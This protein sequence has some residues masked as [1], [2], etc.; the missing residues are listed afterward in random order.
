MKNTRIVFFGTTTFACGILQTLIDEKYNVVAVVS[1]PDKPVGRK[2]VIQPT[3][4]HTLASQYQIPVVQPDVLRNHIEDVLQYEPELILTCAYGQFVPM[5]ILEY[6]KYGCMNVHPSL[7]PKFR[8]GA[9][10]HHAIMHGEEMT[11]VSFIQMTKAMD[12]GD[13]YAQVTTPI[14]KDET[15][16][17]LSDRLLVLSKQMIKDHLEDYI[18][19]NLKPVVQQED[20]VILGLNI[21]KEEEKVSFQSEEVHALYNHIRGL[22]DWPM[23]YGIVDGK[24]MKFTHV[25]MREDNHHKQ[26]GEILGFTNHAME[27]AC[28]GG[29]LEVFEL[30]PEGKSKMSADAYANGAGRQ[31][32]G[33][34][35]E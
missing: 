2:H 11:G 29:I 10:I 1:Q 31:M 23:P 35:F 30:Q 16:A 24:R 32:I 17:Q 5:K 3:P 18:L 20:Q 33:K 14:D 22:I 25:R 27:I 34:V 19:G 15:M 21:T 7:L 6:P 28:Q 8:G 4:T 12:A 26:V 13:I 9:P